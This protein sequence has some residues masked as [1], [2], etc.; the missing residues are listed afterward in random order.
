MQEELFVKKKSEYSP[1]F[2]TAL[3][4]YE[5]IFRDALHRLQAEVIYYL[6]I[7]RF[8]GRR[9]TIISCTREIKLASLP[10]QIYRRLNIA[11][12]HYVQISV[13]NFTPVGQ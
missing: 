5:N 7:I 8:Y 1:V 2:K 11:Q 9:L 4:A 3:L 12:R 6:N 10:V 13:P